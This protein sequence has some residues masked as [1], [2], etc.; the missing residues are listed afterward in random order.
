MTEHLVEIPDCLQ[1]PDEPARRWFS[2]TDLDLIVW[3]SDIKKIL[4]FQF[5]YTGISGKYALTWSEDEGY[6]HNRIDEGEGRAGKAKMSPL[7]LPHGPFDKDKA[8]VQ[9]ETQCHTIDPDISKKVLQSLAA[10]PG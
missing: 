10:Y 2:S 9:F 3:F 5:C 6:H 7:L 8:L 1:V 4:G